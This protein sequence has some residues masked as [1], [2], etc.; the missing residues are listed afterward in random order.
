MHDDVYSE[1]FEEAELA[2]KP[3]YNGDHATVEFINGKVVFA[4]QVGLPVGEL[5]QI[6]IR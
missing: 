2:G 1:M 4:V 6:Q 3:V 5:Q